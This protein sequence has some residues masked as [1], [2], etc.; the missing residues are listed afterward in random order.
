MPTGLQDGS[1][2]QSTPLSASSSLTA[3]IAITPTGIGVAQH[4]SNF[5]SGASTVSQAFRWKNNGGN[6]LLICVGAPAGVTINTPTDTLGNT[7]ASAVSQSQAGAGQSQMFYAKNC[8][9]GPNTNT[10]TVT[11]SASTNI[12]IHIFEITG[13]D[14]NAPLD[15]VGSNGQSASATAL[16][17]S[18]GAPTTIANEYVHAF[19]YCKGQGLQTY[20]QGGVTTSGEI[21]GSGVDSGFSEAYITSATGTQV[22]TA[23]QGI[24]SD[25]SACIATFRAP[26]GFDGSY[27][28]SWNLALGPILGVPGL[29][30]AQLAGGSLK[31]LPSDSFA[32]VLYQVR[33]AYL[34]ALKTLTVA[35]L[36]PAGA[37]LP[38]GSFVIEFQADLIAVLPSNP[39]N[40]GL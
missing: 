12:H 23:T 2:G 1:G 6:L 35:Q 13:C 16:S 10:V 3:A 32:K 21:S 40:V 14:R 19:F 26:T 17:V 33:G 25:Y 8:K 27:A 30:Y 28:V 9:G 38:G 7:F 29:T 24:A 20:T 5:A 39:A 34:E 22:A 36:L 15:Q 11:T 37:P 18:T 4:A 31:M